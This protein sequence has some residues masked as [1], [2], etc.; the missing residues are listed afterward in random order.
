MFV[1]SLLHSGHWQW[2]ITHSFHLGTFVCKMYSEMYEINST[3]IIKGIMDCQARVRSP[4]VQSPKVKTKR[5]WA[6]TK[7]HM[8]L[9]VQEEVYQST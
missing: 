3:F 1:L 6:D 8:G 2:C 4:K 5:T 7:N 9:H